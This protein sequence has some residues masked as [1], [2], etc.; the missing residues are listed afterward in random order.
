MQIQIN[1]YVSMYRQI[2][3]RWHTRERN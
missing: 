3:D 2:R 1:T